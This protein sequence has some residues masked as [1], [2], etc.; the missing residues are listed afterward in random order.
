MPLSD[1]LPA[2]CPAAALKHP[3]ALCRRSHGIAPPEHLDFILLVPDESEAELTARRPGA[4]SLI[5][6]LV[7]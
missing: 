7:A 4:P 5:R 2:D 1:R 6:D 3:I